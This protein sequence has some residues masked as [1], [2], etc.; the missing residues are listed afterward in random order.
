MIIGSKTG[1]REKVFYTGG[2][3]AHTLRVGRSGGI[4]LFHLMSIPL[5]PGG[6]QF[7][8]VQG[9]VLYCTTCP[10]GSALLHYMSKG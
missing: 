1:N 7:S 3:H 9:V 2:S 4:G 10:R 5:P 8:F 6:S